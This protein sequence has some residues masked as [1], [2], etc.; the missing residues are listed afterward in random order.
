M[1]ENML[2]AALLNT[3]SKR[4]LPNAVD[5][6]FLARRGI[7][8]IKNNFCIDDK[9]QKIEEPYIALPVACSYGGYG[10]ERLSAEKGLTLPQQK[11]GYCGVLYNEKKHQ[12]ADQVKRSEIEYLQELFVSVVHETVHWYYFIRYNYP[13]RS[14]IRM[15]NQYEFHEKCIESYSQKFVGEYPDEQK[16]FLLPFRRVR[17]SS[18]DVLPIQYLITHYNI[19]PSGELSLEA[20]LDALRWQRRHRIF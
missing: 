14:Q 18:V 12:F 4:E 7:L 20:R 8:A 1:D 11:Y 2:Q 6:Q 3:G 15:S 10:A 5:L 16:H 19:F 13:Y 9:L 17:R